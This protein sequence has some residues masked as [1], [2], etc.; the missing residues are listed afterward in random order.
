MVGLELHLEEHQPGEDEPAGASNLSDSG[1]P[2]L[3][4]PNQERIGDVPALDWSENDCEGDSR[5][6]DNHHPREP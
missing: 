2:K 5:H 6:D 1:R 3:E 4:W